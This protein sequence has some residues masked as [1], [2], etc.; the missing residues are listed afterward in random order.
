[1]SEFFVIVKSVGQRP[2]RVHGRLAVKKVF[3]GVSFVS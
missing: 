1:M 2:W 3:N